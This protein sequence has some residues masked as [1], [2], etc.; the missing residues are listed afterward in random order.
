MEVSTESRVSLESTETGMLR[1]DKINFKIGD[2][3]HINEE[4]GATL[5]LNKALEANNTLIIH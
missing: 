1:V 2:D 4:T 5:L 3:G